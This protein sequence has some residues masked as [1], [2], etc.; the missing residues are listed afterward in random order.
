MEEIHEFHFKL[1]ITSNK[2]DP[3]VELVYFEVI[4]LPSNE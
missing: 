4:K 1:F 2:Y 3:V